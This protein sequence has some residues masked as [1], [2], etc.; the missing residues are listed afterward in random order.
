MRYFILTLTL[1]LLVF[2]ACDSKKESDGSGS[3][4]ENGEM[5]QSTGGDGTTMQSGDSGTDSEDMSDEQ[6]DGPKRYQL[7]SGI[8]KYKLSGDQSGTEELYFDRWGMR[9]AKYADRTVHMGEMKQTMEEMVM[10]DG[11]YAYNVDLKQRVG[12]KMKN[13]MIEELLAK[14]TKDFS[15]VV[16]AEMK[17]MGGVKKGTEKVLQ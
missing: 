6:T 9:E 11:K 7:Q 12:M 5:T 8:V 1:A 13:P 15:E 2:T 3:D 14:G 16:E 10:F 17:R 4:V